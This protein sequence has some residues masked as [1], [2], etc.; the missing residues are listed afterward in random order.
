MILDVR[1]PKRILKLS[2]YLFG[3]ASSDIPESI[4]P[5]IM[6]LHQGQKVTRV[7]FCVIT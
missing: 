6:V 2:Y 5:T 4:M 3:Q 7:A 1:L